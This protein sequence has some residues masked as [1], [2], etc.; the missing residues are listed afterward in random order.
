MSVS[1]TGYHEPDLAYDSKPFSEPNPTLAM[2]NPTPPPPPSYEHTFLA[3]SP[4]LAASRVQSDS[5]PPFSL[6]NTHLV[7]STSQPFSPPPYYFPTPDPYSDS[8]TDAPPS[9]LSTISDPDADAFFHNP[10]PH[11][12]HNPCPPPPLVV[13]LPSSSLPDPLAMPDAD[14]VSNAP[15]TASLSSTVF[16]PPLPLFYEHLP[17]L[18][19]PSTSPPPLHTASTILPPPD[20]SIYSISFDSSNSDDTISEDSWDL[21]SPPSTPP[22][23]PTSPHRTP[24]CRTDYSYNYILS[25]VATLDGID[26]PT[27]YKLAKEIFMGI[28]LQGA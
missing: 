22:P 9:P 1:T 28:N 8:P 20:H 12:M 17:P 11:P 26:D 3:V 4:I 14:A 6:L 19:P 27:T 5:P 21:Y 13:P 24:T 18:P 2:P 10:L 23:P 16:V 7:P 25:R 15:S